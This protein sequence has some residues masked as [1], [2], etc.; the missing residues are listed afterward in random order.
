MYRSS[1]MRTEYELANARKFSATDHKLIISGTTQYVNSYWDSIIFSLGKE[2]LN[3]IKTPIRQYLNKT[4]KLVKFASLSK[5]GS[6][7]SGRH[8]SIWKP[9]RWSSHVD[10]KILFRPPICN[11]FSC[12]SP[13]RIIS[14]LGLRQGNYFDEG[15]Q[16]QVAIFCLFP[17]LDPW[18]KVKISS[19]QLVFT[20]ELFSTSQS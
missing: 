1:L 10:A 8:S 2:F 15:T 4:K 20:A 13:T 5:R 16:R 17:L 9:G 19:Y 18:P 6:I 7:D 3:Y 12:N 11:V 14:L